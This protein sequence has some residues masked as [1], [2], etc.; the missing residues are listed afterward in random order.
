MRI[1][2]NCGFLFRIS[3]FFITCIFLSSS[4]ETDGS[5]E[6]GKASDRALFEKK[7]E[8][9][10]NRAARENEEMFT[11]S[12]RTGGSRPRRSE[13]IGLGTL[14]IRIAGYLSL[15]AVLIVGIAWFLRKNGARGG[16]VM[17][18]ATDVIETLPIGQGRHVTL[19]RIQDTILVVG[20]TPHNVVLLDR[21]EGQK[22]VELIATG[23]GGTSIEQFK[24]VFSS[25]VGKM[26]KSS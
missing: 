16:T 8:Y 22:A 15:V 14:I 24:D 21:I 6:A 25:F 9:A 17:G 2:T 12:I 5:P 18:G 11:D 10:R 4:A 23:K 20:H 3:L 7:L 1:L 19:V 26:K 13:S